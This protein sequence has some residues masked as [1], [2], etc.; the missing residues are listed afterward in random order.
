MRDSQKAIVHR[1][2]ES[3]RHR[4]SIR[5]KFQEVGKRKYEYTSYYD[6]LSSFGTELDSEPYGMKFS[7]PIQEVPTPH[8][9]YDRINSV[10]DLFVDEKW[11]S[12]Q[13]D[14]ISGLSKENLFDIFGYTYKGDV[15]VNNFIRGTLDHDK[16]YEDIA[17]FKNSP[18]AFY[19][20]LFFPTLHVL[21]HIPPKDLASILKGKGKNKKD[22]P[23]SVLKSLQ[24][25]GPSLLDAYEKV[26]NIAE[27][28]NMIF[29]HD[30]IREYVRRLQDI[31]G[32]AP[33]TTK[34]MVLYRGSK[35]R[36]YM[37]HGSQPSDRG[38]EHVSASFL[39]TTSSVAV[40]RNFYDADAQCCLMRFVVHPGASL[41]LMMGT[42]E[43]TEERE[44]LLPPG[45]RFVA[46][47]SSKVVIDVFEKQTRKKV[48]ETTMFTTDFSMN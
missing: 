13:N 14:Y 3:F 48:G 15:F 27:H 45:S 31:I 33:K 21:K 39:S 34:K 17:S 23:S 9:M 40:A 37:P 35:T 36:Y 30:V 8:L 5:S 4:K 43:Y 1:Y 24:S 10:E 11:F 46:L 32:N 28:L 2:V 29:W 47:Q 25:G 44:F 41:L 38:Y 19:F 7:E 22:G 12:L 18:N 20:P 26:I 16:F 6:Y 42:T